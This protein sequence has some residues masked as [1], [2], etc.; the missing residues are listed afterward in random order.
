MY[1]PAGSDWRKQLPGHD[2][3]RQ[4]LVEVY[5]GHGN[6]EVLPAWRPVDVARDGSLSC[7]EP[8]GGYLPSC[9]HAGELVEARC[10]E[11]GESDDDCGGRAADARANYVAA[12]QAGWKTLPGYEPNDWVNAGQAPPDL[13]LIHI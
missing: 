2:P 3:K 13:S 9:W 7:P 10:K 8:R 11:V 1:T 12:H 6:S 4:T 5:S